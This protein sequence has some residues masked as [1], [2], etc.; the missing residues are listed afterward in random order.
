MLKYST[1]LHIT[2]FPASRSGKPKHSPDDYARTET[3]LTGRIMKRDG[4]YGLAEACAGRFGRTA[5]GSLNYA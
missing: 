1:I 4:V 3:D 5:N 2:L